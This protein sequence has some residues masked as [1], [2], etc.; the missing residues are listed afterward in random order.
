MSTTAKLT[1]GD[2]DRMIESGIFAP[3]AIARMLDEHA[4]G[5]IDHATPLWLLL[6]FEGFLAGGTCPL[7]RPAP[8]L[9][10]AS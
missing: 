6:V 7:G 1:L 2:Y 9:A 4:S 5:R 10:F 8:E 3:A